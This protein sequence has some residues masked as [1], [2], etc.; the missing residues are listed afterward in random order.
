[1]VTSWIITE[2]MAGT[3]NQ[4]LGVAEALHLSPAVLRIQL[5]QPWK[6]FSPY[7]PLEQSWSFIPPLCG[8]WP[9]LLITSGR[10]AIAAARYIKRQ[11]PET[12]TL[13]LQDPRVS[14]DIFD[15]V[16]VPHHDALRADNV[17]VTDGAPNRI[18][19]ERLAS[20]NKIDGVGR[21][22]AG[23]LI[24]GNSKTHRLTDA[25]MDRLIRHLK[26]LAQ[27]YKLL[28]TISRRTDHIQAQKLKDA[29]ADTDAYV[30]DGTGE[31]P[32]F[33]ILAQADYLLVTNDSASMISDA[34]TTGKPVYLIPL[35]GGSPKFTRLYDHFHNLGITREFH[36]ILENWTYT[37]LRDAQKIADSVRKASGLF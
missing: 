8:P 15:L 10:K 36:G 1:M 11:N 37:P 9:D 6:L 30:W 33:S 35:E 19:P 25:A 27:A 24:G 4:C 13:H 31:N 18:T 14:A 5:R 2:G 29:L 7:M 22:M 3:E 20:A 26:K 28:I 34:A 16:A 17:I 21:E 23:V 12:F 32:Y